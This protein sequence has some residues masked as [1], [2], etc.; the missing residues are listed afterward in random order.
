MCAGMKQD[1]V[2]P[3][4]LLQFQLPL[5][6]TAHATSHR[7]NCHQQQQVRCI[8]VLWSQSNTT[9]QTNK[10]PAINH[11][12]TIYYTGSSSKTTSES[13]QDGVSQVSQW[14]SM[15]TSGKKAENRNV[16]R[17]WWNVG[18]VRTEITLSGR[19]FQMVG[20]A[21]EKDQLPMV[22]SLMDGTSKQ[23]VQAEQRKRHDRLA[24]WT[25]WVPLTSL[26]VHNN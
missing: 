26:N 20:P 14:L 1:V 5:R 12:I 25:S 8:L 16:L 7:Q 22:D 3:Q 2:W 13:T 18:R 23:L 15:M 10:S 9:S 17:C 19:V 6:P 24:T 4:C 21:T 11:A